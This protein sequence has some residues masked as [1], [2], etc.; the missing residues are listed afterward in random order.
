MIVVGIDVG[1]TFTDGVAWSLTA[2]GEPTGATR[3]IKVMSTP[4]DPKQAVFD[5]L[6]RLALPLSGIDRIIHGTTLATNTVIQRRGARVGL[7]STDGHRDTLDIRRGIRPFGHIHDL[8]WAPPPPLVRRGLRIGIA[9]RIDSHGQVLAPINPADLAAMIAFFAEQEVEAVAV[10]LLFSYANDAHEREVGEALARGLPH[11][12]VSFSSAILPQWREYERTST[13]VADA[14]VK[15]IMGDYLRGLADGLAARGYRGTLHVMKSNGGVMTARR[16]AAIPIETYLSGPAGGVVAGHFIGRQTRRSGLLVTDMGG[17]SFE[18]SAVTPEGYTTT[19]ESEIDLTLPIALPMLD[20]R[21]IGAGGGSIAWI[22]V[23]GALKVGPQSAGAL[24]G[25]A[26]YD[27]GGMQ[28]TITD[29]NVVLGRLPDSLQLAGSYRIAGPLARAA[30]GPLAGQL[31]QT[32][33]QLALGMIRVCVSNMVGQIR[34][35]TSERG[36]DPRDYTLVAG[37]GAGPLHGVQ[38]AAELG[39]DTVIVPAYPG[40]LSA[41]GLVQSDVRLDSVRSYPVL[42]HERSY[43]SIR[44]TLQRMIGDGVALLREEGHTG[45]RSLEVALDVRYE[46]QNWQIQVPISLDMQLAD[47][48]RAFDDE[49]ERLYGFRLEQHAREIINLRVAAVGRLVHAEK[50]TPTRAPSRASATGR[51]SYWDEVAGAPAEASLVERDSIGSAWSDVGPMV[52]SGSDSVVWVPPQ[53]TARCDAFGNL[54][55]HLRHSSGHGA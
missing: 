5:T 12:P 8:Q 49:H 9:G 2:E 54:H 19:T 10:S 14:Y 36:L 31:G 46:G 34:A 40:L 44:S 45:D 52:I 7:V 53:V 1:G 11:L 42:L 35:I 29:A 47:L 16:A 38:I 13:T 51:T 27:R 15:P 21:T 6:D 26:C 41:A 43:D 30:L 3:Y 32:V 17:T 50:L 48:A 20:V 28:P 37:G 33:E 39:I 55:L 24:P 23:G 18:V 4:Q 22:D 25:P